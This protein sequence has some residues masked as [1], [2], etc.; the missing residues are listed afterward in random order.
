MMMSLAVADLR[1]STISDIG[2]EASVYHSAISERSTHSTYDPPIVNDESGSSTPK[3]DQEKGVMILSF[4]NEDVILRMKTTQ[5]PS[6]TQPQSTS[7]GPGGRPSPHRAPS[8]Y[9]GS[10]LPSLDLDV[11]VGTIALMLL[12]GQMASLLSMSQAFSHGGSDQALPTATARET[13]QPKL[14]GR[15][16]VKGV[17]M[18]LIYDMTVESNP[19][20]SDSI[21]TYWTRPSTTYLPVGH[22]NFKVEGLEAAYSSKGY[23]P[24]SLSHN[25]SRPLPRRSSTTSTIRFGLRPPV[26]N[27][28]VADL[29][30]FEYIATDT[31]PAAADG[32]P[33]DSI[34]GGAYPVVLF[35]AGL[36]KQYDVIPPGGRPAHGPSPETFPEFDSVDWR[37]SGMHKKSGVGEKAWKVRPKGKGAMKAAPG[38]EVDSSPVLLLRKELARAS[39]E[40]QILSHFRRS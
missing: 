28:R 16:R 31:T 4:G 23:T 15:I 5:P 21:S 38:N 35:D 34:P 2:S 1:Q 26:I 11:S 36:A 30:I 25:T 3:R 18:S 17:Y 32:E 20:F 12:P 13:A 9:A 33:D 37:N 22:L 27:L 10:T 24:R 7:A 29:S 6:G 40:L 39:R 14:D 19:T 8:S